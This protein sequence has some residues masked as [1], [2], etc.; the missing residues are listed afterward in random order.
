[1]KKILSI[2]ALLLITFGLVS[3]S[4]NSVFKKNPDSNTFT[5]LL[6]EQT[7]DDQ[8]SGSHLLVDDTGNVIEPLRS[9]SIN[10]SSSKYLNNKVQVIGEISKEDEVFEVSGLS[11]LEVMDKDVPKIDFSEYK[12]TDLGFKIKYYTDWKIEEVGNRITFNAPVDNMSA[13]ADKIVITQS[14]FIYEL[15]AVTEENIDITADSSPTAT[16]ISDVDI[17]K[18]ALKKYVVE[19]NY[20]LDEPADDLIHKVGIDRVDAL[21]IEKANGDVD[22]FMYRSGFIYQVSFISAASSH[23]AENKNVFNEMLAE[24]QFLGF[25]VQDNGNIDEAT[26]ILDQPSD[27][28]ESNDDDL[29]MTNSEI[30]VTDLESFEGMTSFESSIYH[31]SSKYPKDWY[32]AGIRGTAGDVLHHYGFSNQSVTSSNELIGLDVMGSSAKPDGQYS[33]GNI[34]T[35][36]ITIDGRTYRISGDTQYKEIIVSMAK[37]ITPINDETLQIN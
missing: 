28:P 29:E 8:Y 23:V 12:N 30:F 19:N 13:D 4:L 34:F 35:V 3:C 26:V 5:G 25:T 9:L 21:K 15:P 1:M 32:Y 37:S 33:S 36:Y 31:F 10:L 17:A 14:P 20:E 24:F 2:S 11:V 27:Q 18:E 6:V 16:D 7:P 22:Y